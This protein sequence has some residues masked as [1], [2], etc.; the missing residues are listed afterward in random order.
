MSNSLNSFFTFPSTKQSARIGVTTSLLPSVEGSNWCQ[1]SY[2]V[3]ESSVA[4]YSCTSLDLWILNAWPRLQ[5]IPQ[6]QGEEII[7]RTSVHTTFSLLQNECLNVLSYP[8][9]D[10]LHRKEKAADSAP[11]RFLEAEAQVKKL[12]CRVSKFGI[13]GI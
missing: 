2:I 11:F 8:T 9:F 1:K 13:G 3:T 4:V 7:I 6:R 5:V 12:L 10:G